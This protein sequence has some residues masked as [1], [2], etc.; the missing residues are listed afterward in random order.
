MVGGV[1]LVLW[2][3]F[4][5]HGAHAPRLS[6]GSPVESSTTPRRDSWADRHHET[7]AG[8][9]VDR[10]N[11]Q[12]LLTGMSER[13][14]SHEIAMQRPKKRLPEDN[15]PIGRSVIGRL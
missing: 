15:R 2:C 13:V 10:R 5:V 8:P 7:A 6:V 12:R 4:R 9:H 1:R 11:Q 14:L 3:G